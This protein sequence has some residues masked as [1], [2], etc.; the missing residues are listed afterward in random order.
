MPG[1]SCSLQKPLRRAQRKA[2]YA[3]EKKLICSRQGDKSNGARA[4]KNWEQ[5]TGI[6]LVRGGG[7]SLSSPGE[8]PACSKRNEK[9]GESDQA[10]VLAA[11]RDDLS[12]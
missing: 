10:V 4:E 6:W 3:L 11:H 1:E 7:D 2:A 8:N 5:E 12:C 9:R